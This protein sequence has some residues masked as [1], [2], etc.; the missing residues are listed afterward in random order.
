MEAENK[1]NKL[2]QDCWNKALDAFAY[3]QIFNA[4]IARYGNYLSM[5]TLFG[6]LVP[7]FV[8]A[9]ALSYAY[10]K[11]LMDLVLAIATPLTIIQFVI[12]VCSIVFKW[13]DRL[14]YAM[15]S[16]TEHTSLC[17]QYRKLANTPPAT[18]S[19]LAHALEMVDITYMQRTRQ[20]VKAGIAHWE[21]RRGMRAGLRNF[22]RKCAG[23]RTVPLSVDSTD[24]DVCGKFSLKYRIF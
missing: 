8:G 12:S 19:E 16:A 2:R 24:C 3:S 11:A 13:D 20:D 10:N 21:E 5:L 23:C 6:I 14:S 4:R 18:E 22:G 1:Y 7:A 15:E 9:F 17:E